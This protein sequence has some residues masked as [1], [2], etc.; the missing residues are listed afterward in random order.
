MSEKSY[1]L[2][3][4]L[5][6]CRQPTGHFCGSC[7]DLINGAGFREAIL[8]FRKIEGVETDF[9][10]PYGKDW[11]P[12]PTPSPEEHEEMLKAQAEE[13]KEPL[14][15]TKKL[16]SGCSNCSRTKKGKR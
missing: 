10:C 3:V 12:I 11:L 14:T 7:R 15:K 4:V 9:D 16:K 2:P 1:K 5:P 8:Q 13:K 6:E